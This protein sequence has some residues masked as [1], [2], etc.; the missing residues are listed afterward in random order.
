M[1]P[2]ED[3]WLNNKPMPPYNFPPA[4]LEPMRRRAEEWLLNDEGPRKQLQEFVSAEKSYEVMDGLLFSGFC[5]DRRQPRRVRPLP[6]L[7][8]LLYRVP[9]P[10]TPEELES[11]MIEV[12]AR[13]LS[14]WC[15]HYLASGGRLDTAP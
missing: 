5:L 13:A 9:P 12:F 15:R 2:W 3:A 4:L 8:Q 11:A 14:E 10:T 1:E 6:V 7:V